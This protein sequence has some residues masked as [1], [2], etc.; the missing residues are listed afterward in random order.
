[1]TQQC[2]N[3][4]ASAVTV[5]YTGLEGGTV[6]L[7]SAVQHQ[8]PLYSWKVAVSIPYGVTGIFYCFKPSGLSIEL[9]STQTPK[10]MSTRG[11][12]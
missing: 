6:K 2:T 9:G 10:Q 3:S 11:I 1:M 5:H 7:C 4:A 12:C 8:S